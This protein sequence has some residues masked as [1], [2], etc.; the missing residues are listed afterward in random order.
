MSKPSAA[1]VAKPVRRPSAARKPTPEL[2]TGSSAPPY[3]PPRSLES[4]L[5]SQIR[6]LRRER[7]LSVADLAGASGISV[8]MLSKIENGQ[9][10]P[11]LATIQSIANAL[12]TQ[13]TTLFSAFEDRRDC[14]YVPKGHGVSIERRGTKSGHLYELLG[15]G[16]RGDLAVEPYL[17]TLKKGA[18][19]Y[20][21]FRH[22][23]TEFI[24]MLSGEVVYRHG[25]ED[26]HL[27]PGDSLLF[28]SGALHGPNRLVSMPIT[29]LSIIIYS[30]TRS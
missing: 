8:G 6:L 4:A 27:R 5:G 17:I 9:I 28:D 1:A 22:A 14:S 25:S 23:G 18:E 7:E 30:R 11:S 19:P 29:F 16:V 3:D 21:G 10:S 13:F 20:T 15:A 26:Y 2:T 24:Y 12:N